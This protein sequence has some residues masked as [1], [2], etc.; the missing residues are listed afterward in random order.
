MVRLTTLSSLVG[1]SRQHQ[2]VHIGFVA[3]PLEHLDAIQAGQHDVQND[4]VGPKGARRLERG[5]AIASCLNGVALFFQVSL[6]CFDDALL[7][8]DDQNFCHFCR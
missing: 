2:H 5:Q 8:V 3:Q 4:Q 7:V 1:A 6:N